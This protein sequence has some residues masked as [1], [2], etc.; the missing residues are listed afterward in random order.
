MSSEF[1][2]DKEQKPIHFN[3]FKKRNTRGN[4][5]QTMKVFYFLHNDW[6]EHSSLS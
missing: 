1:W 4:D 3:Y 2:D 5:V 6:S